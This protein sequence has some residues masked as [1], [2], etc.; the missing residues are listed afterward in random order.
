MYVSITV[1]KHKACYLFLKVV[2]NPHVCMHV[3]AF[4]GGLYSA[5]SVQFSYFHTMFL[6]QSVSSKGMQMAPC[7]FAEFVKLNFHHSSLYDIVRIHTVR[8]DPGRIILDSV[9]HAFFVLKYQ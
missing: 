7:I 8:I 1:W 4:T 5:C 2:A 6:L 3:C 9:F